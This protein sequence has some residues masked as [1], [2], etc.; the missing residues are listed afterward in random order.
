MYPNVG[1]TKRDLKNPGLLGTFPLKKIHHASP[2]KKKPL[3]K[4]QE[5]SYPMPSRTGFKLTQQLQEP[6][7]ERNFPN[8]T[9]VEQQKKNL[10]MAFQ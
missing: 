6:K 7:M 5:A 8:S 10:G 1:E 2:Q 3:K 4:A 9:P